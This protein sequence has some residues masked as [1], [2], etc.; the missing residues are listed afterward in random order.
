ML[1]SRKY[2]I[3][4]DSADLREIFK[5]RLK[6]KGVSAYSVA[7]SLQIDIDN[8]NKWVSGAYPKAMTQWDVLMAAKALGIN[9][10]LKI[11]V[12]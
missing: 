12:E 11:E 1:P 9:V 6:Q 3:V 5:A 4:R 10:S 8:F 2:C 7:R